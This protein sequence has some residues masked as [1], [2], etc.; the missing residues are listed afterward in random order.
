MTRKDTILIAVVVNSAL[1]ITLFATAMTREDKQVAA[2][3]NKVEKLQS[4]PIVEAP[5]KVAKTG[6]EI[7]QVLQEFT[8][9][10]DKAPKAIDFAKELEAITKA[11][12]PVEKKKP[13]ATGNQVTVKKGDSLDKIAR[14]NGVSVDALVSANN[15]TNTVLQIGQVLK[16]PARGE[17]T[18]AAGGD[19]FYT[20]KQGDNPWTIAVKNQLKVDELLKLNN[21]NE[22]KARR[23]RPGD[24]LRIR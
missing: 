17:S 23:L 11:A 18:Q 8:A 10:E 15:L 4:I 24:K 12:A 16:I 7:D 5:K 14:A 2:A 20:V 1:L 13:L 6:D 3:V 9:K 22:E 19:Q 21:L